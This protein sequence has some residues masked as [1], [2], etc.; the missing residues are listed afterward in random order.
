MVWP[1]FPCA[2]QCQ[3]F[4]SFTALHP[5][6]RPAVS[7]TLPWLQQSSVK[8]SMSASY[9]GFPCVSPNTGTCD[10]PIDPFHS[11][12]LRVGFRLLLSVF[13]CFLSIF[14]CFYLFRLFLSAFICLYLFLSVSNVYL[15][16][17]ALAALYPTLVTGWVTGSLGH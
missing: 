14:I 6:T 2:R 4:I 10:G 16:L 15:F 13:I 8:G 5:T 9:G 7:V 3:R 17:A 12:N 1:G 11:V